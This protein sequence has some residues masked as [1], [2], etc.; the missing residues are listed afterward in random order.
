MNLLASNTVMQIN[1]SVIGSW[2]WCFKPSWI[3][4][5]PT[6]TFA[7]F[8]IPLSYN[9]SHLRS[10]FYR[11]SS[12]STILG[13]DLCSYFLWGEYTDLANPHS[14][15]HQ[16]PIH[17]LNLLLYGSIN[18]WLNHHLVWSVIFREEYIRFSG[19]PVWYCFFRHFLLHVV[20]NR[21]MLVSADISSHRTTSDFTVLQ[22]VVPL[23]K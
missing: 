8:K 23:L 14:C 5:L 13:C 17:F 6:I 16:Q 10:C 9:F 18:S 20:E 4:D 1:S 19:D 21:F 11:L 15:C 12:Q 22:L 7:R 2:I 3:K